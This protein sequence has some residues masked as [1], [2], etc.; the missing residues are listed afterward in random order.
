ML[1]QTEF[2]NATDIVE[3]CA[4]FLGQQLDLRQFRH[5]KPL[6]SS[7]LTISAGDNG[8]A[9]LFRYGVVVLIGMQS[10]ERT[11]FIAGI[12]AMISEP[13]E[14]PETENF[15]I[16]IDTS[17]PEGM[18]QE[19]ICLHAF[20]L[21]RLQIVADVLAKST[22]LSHYE[23]SLSRHFDRIEPVAESIR[24]GNHRGSKSRELLQ[25]IGDT[26]IIEAKMTGRL[27]ITEKPELIW[28]YPQYDRLYLRLE[29]EFEL[30]E[31]HAAIDRKLA[32]ISKTAQTLLDLIH[33]E[34]SLRVEWYI[35]ILIIVDIVIASVEKML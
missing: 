35:V 18:E 17:L 31:R 33:G 14:Q 6:S 4:I 15:Q 22:V 27:E 9:V 32:L 25:H 23:S 16:F 1:M 28:D 3:G 21:Q 20:N 7:P 5:I 2:Y 26:L 29:D 24:R 30:S 10:S 8:M 12:Q 19:R 34:R 11:D 13:F